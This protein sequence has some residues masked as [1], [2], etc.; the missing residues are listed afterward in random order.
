MDQPFKFRSSLKMNRGSVVMTKLTTFCPLTKIKLSQGALKLLTIPNAGGSSV[1]SEVLSLEFLSRS[2]GAHLLKTEM[3][4]EYWPQGGSIT[5]YVARIYDQI[6]GVSVTRAMKY[7]GDFAMDDAIRLLNKKLQGVNRST[8]N[9]QEGWSKQVLHVWATDK[10]TAAYVL[11]AWQM[12][13]ET[14]RSDTVVVIT[15]CYSIPG[16]FF[17]RKMG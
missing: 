11:K 3:E 15:V 10:K 5:D 7:G 16:L 2:F 8:A 1:I 12:L 6:I 14:V 13:D 17:E 9:N 4:V